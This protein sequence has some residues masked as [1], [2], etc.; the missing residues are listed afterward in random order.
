MGFRYVVI[1]CRTEVFI[2]PGIVFGR[3][4]VKIQMVPVLTVTRNGVRVY[5]GDFIDFFES[6]ASRRDVTFPSAKQIEKQ[7]VD[8]S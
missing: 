6:L 7:A 4:C 3:I 5:P 1:D 8:C 2:H